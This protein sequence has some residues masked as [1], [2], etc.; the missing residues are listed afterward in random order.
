[1]RAAGLAVTSLLAACEAQP[2][3]QPQEAPLPRCGLGA[4]AALPTRPGEALDPRRTPLPIDDAGAGDSAAQAR[5]GRAPRRLDVDQL[6]VS[7]EALLGAPWVGPRAVWTPESP[8][9]RR[10]EPEADL[11]EFFASA[12]GRPD[13]VNST[14]EVLEPTITFAKLLSDAARSVC[15]E[16]LR[17][18]LARPPGERRILLEVSPTDTLPASE[19]AVRRNLAA[20]A[21]RLWAAELPPEGVAVSALLGVFRVALAQRSATPM[22]AWRAVCIDLVTDPRFFTY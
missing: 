21:L 22:D 12:L 8:S 4:G 14:S 16:G 1:M 2:P 11:A 18:D 17:R 5:V 3:A 19:A 6:R 10:F 20:L 9:G 7:F 15:A 13:Y